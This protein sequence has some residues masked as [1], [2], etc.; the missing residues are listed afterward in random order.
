MN[1]SRSLIRFSARPSDS[2]LAAWITSTL[3]ITTGRAAVDHPSG[4]RPRPA[5]HQASGERSPNRTL[6]RTPP[7]MVAEPLQP[8]LDVEEP[9]L[10]GH[11]VLLTDTATGA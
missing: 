3:T 1:E 10:Q 11:C 8:I 9:G 6:P 4:H 7:I 5:P 2:P